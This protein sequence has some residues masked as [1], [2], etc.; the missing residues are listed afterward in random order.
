[1]TKITNSGNSYVLPR[2]KLAQREAAF[3]IYRDMGPRRSLVSLDH[4]LKCNHPEIAVSRQSL[5]KW[6]KMHH[7]VAR[8]R[9]HDNSVI[10][11]PPQAGLKADPNF[12]HV[13]ALLQA[14]N[15]ALTRAM[16]SAPM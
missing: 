4:E 12:D 7:W 1:M 16:S 11:A 2:N 15:Q 8:V 5:E 6:S 9:A 10:T 3:A 14:A 13:D